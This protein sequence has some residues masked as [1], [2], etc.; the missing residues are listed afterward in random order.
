MFSI[1]QVQGIYIPVSVRDTVLS[2]I[3]YHLLKNPNYY[4]KRIYFT[5]KIDF[6]MLEPRPLFAPMIWFDRMISRDEPGIVLTA[7]DK[8][9]THYGGIPESSLL[10][11]AVPNKA[12]TLWRVMRD[13]SMSNHHLCNTGFIKLLQNPDVVLD[14]EEVRYIEDHFVSDWVDRINERLFDDEVDL[15]MV[16]RGYGHLVY[17]MLWGILKNTQ[18]SFDVKETVAQFIVTSAYEDPALVFTKG[19]IAS[20]VYNFKTLV[21]YLRHYPSNDVA[22]RSEMAD[23]ARILDPYTAVE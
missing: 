4:R 9:D 20:S 3:P 18:F 16:Q 11:G 19:V 22:E 13:M 21:H 5:N 7:L 8:F 12:Q 1:S 6:Y 23:F 10:L 2:F 14:V 17:A 15:E